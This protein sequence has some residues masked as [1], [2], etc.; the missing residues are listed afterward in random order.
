MSQKIVPFLWFD[1]NA[2]EAINL[3]VSLFKN[4]KWGEVTRKG[5]D[6]PIFSATFELEGVEFY[7][8]NGGPMFK[9]TEAISLFVNCETQEEIDELWSKLSAGGKEKQCG[10]LEDKFGLVWQIIP[11]A[12]MRMM[13]DPDPEKVQ[14]VTQAMMKMVKLD[15]S[16]LKR[17]YEGA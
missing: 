11:T 8:L 9:F 12:L 6:G 7:A 15:L 14:R 17:A 16:A 4:S 10:W 3:Y 5:P 13:R 2:E 1:N